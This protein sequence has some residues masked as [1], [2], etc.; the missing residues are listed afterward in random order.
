MGALV[1]PAI[2]EPPVPTEL[3]TRR[4]CRQRVSDLRPTHLPMLGGVPGGDRI[5]DLLKAQDLDQPVEQRRRVMVPNG[6]DEAIGVQIFAKIGKI[7]CRPGKATRG[8]HQ[9]R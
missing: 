7:R 3:R 6:A 2:L 8:V 1:V 5:G 9:G 4:P